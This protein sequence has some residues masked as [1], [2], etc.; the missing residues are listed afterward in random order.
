MTTKEHFAQM[1]MA[2]TINGQA[3][4]ESLWIDNVY[5]HNVM[6]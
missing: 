1:V 4:G 6:P 3:S 5:F 2:S